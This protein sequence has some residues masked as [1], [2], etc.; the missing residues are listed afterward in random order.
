[1][2]NGLNMKIKNWRYRIGDIVQIK[3]E[4]WPRT[5]PSFKNS[6]GSIERKGKV[7]AH[8]AGWS[9]PNMF[10]V[11]WD[12]IGVFG[13]YWSKESIELYSPKEYNHPHTKIFK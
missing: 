10:D 4:W 3:K 8:V 9:S 11:Y 7:I 1:M 13:G 2:V 5:D 6:F 12:E